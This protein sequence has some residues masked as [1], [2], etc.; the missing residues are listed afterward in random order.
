MTWKVLSSKYLFSD[1]WFKVRKERCE[2]PTGKIV[3][4]YYVY[5]FT[6]WVGVLPITE[7]G[8]IVLIRQYRHALGEICIEVPGGCVDSN[9]KDLEA[10]ACREV[11]EETGYVF[12]A[13]QYLGKVSPNPSTNSNLFHMFLATG[14]K[15][16]GEQ[17]L[18][19]QEEIEVFEVS[20]EE[21]KAMLRANEIVQSMHISCML[22]GLEKL[23]LL[24]Y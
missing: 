14:G 5:E 24:S 15:R 13:Y 3:D 8:K 1:R 7:E 16:M 18:D 11:R 12:T 2:T 21:L 19:E 6:P 20:V 4:P 17:Q 22:Y 9:D 10:A 23:N